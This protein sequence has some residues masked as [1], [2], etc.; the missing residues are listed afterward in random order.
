MAH[1]ALG[2]LRALARIPFTGFDL[3]E[4]SP[5]FDGPGQA[6]AL[7]AASMAYEMLTLI[8]IAHVGDAG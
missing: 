3:V 5:Q 8:A 1:E 2:F 7:N 6:T 4:V